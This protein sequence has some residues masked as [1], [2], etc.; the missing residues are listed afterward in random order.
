MC[1]Y[2]D[3]MFEKCINF[4]ITVKKIKKTKESIK[5]RN[6]RHQLTKR[7]EDRFLGR[8]GVPG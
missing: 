2:G 3:W 6:R 1:K 8:Y 7:T 5:F 4:N